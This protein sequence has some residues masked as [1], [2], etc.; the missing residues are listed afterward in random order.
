MVDLEGDVEGFIPVS[1]LGLSDLQTPQTHFS[2]QDELPIKV[3]EFD[4]EQRKI[5]L[6]VKEYLRDVEQAEIDAYIESHGP[7]PVTV[8]EVVGAA[9]GSEESAGD[10]DSA[11]DP[12][13]PAGEPA[14]GAETESVDPGALAGEPTDE[15][16]TESTE[17]VAGEDSPP[18][19]ETSD[20]TDETGDASKSDV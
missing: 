18:S 15:A 6:S 16:E 11:V 4:E 7:K 3:V 14:D 13:A 2:E 5:V 20:T 8:G 19:A 17:D 1:Q 12:G 10:A 9:A